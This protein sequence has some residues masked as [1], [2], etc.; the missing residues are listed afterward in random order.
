[1]S[2]KMT[3]GGPAFPRFGMN[4]WDKPHTADAGMSKREMIAMHV[5]GGMA[6]SAGFQ[7]LPWGRCSAEAVA[8]ADALLA[9]L[10]TEDR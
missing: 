7:G 1:M 9:A 6:T 5:L 4:A 10:R 2:E 8:A 3:D